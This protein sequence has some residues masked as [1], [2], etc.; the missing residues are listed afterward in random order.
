M[1][2]NRLTIPGSTQHPP[3][4]PRVLHMNLAQTTCNHLLERPAVPPAKQHAAKAADFHATLGSAPGP[5]PQ[6]PLQP[7]D[8]CRRRTQWDLLHHMFARNLAEQV[9]ILCRAKPL[10]HANMD[11]AKDMLSPAMLLQQSLQQAHYF[12]YKNEQQSQHERMRRATSARN[13]ARIQGSVTCNRNAGASSCMN[14]LLSCTVS[15]W[16]FSLK[17]AMTLF[18]MRGG[19]AR[20]CT[21]RWAC[22]QTERQVHVDKAWVHSRE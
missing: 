10:G 6:L 17:Y 9:H 19:S 21:S 16:C 2:S 11:Y 12:L 4:R 1:T 18:A 8:H 20:R 7:A 5:R 3:S 13:Q 14:A 15:S 22:T